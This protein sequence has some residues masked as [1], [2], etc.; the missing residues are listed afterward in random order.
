MSPFELS[1]L[2]IIAVFFAAS[3]LILLL[4]LWLIVHASPAQRAAP[5][6]EAKAEIRP[7]P[8]EAVREEGFVV[9]ALYDDGVPLA[10]TAYGRRR[11]PAGDEA[12]AIVRTAKVRDPESGAVRLLRVV[13]ASRASR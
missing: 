9:I 5:P 7:Q 10:T 11:P 3:G 1:D 6:E 2:E 8:L 4:S 13:T 12:Q